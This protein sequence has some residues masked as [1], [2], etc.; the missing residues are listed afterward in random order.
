MRCNFDLAALA[1]GMTVE[2][3]LSVKVKGSLTHARFAA[4]ISRLVR[5]SSKYVAH[6][7][8]R[9]HTGDHPSQ[10]L[11]DQNDVDSFIKEV[12]EILERIKR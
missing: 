3:A 4:E 2:E 10:D 11:V 5:I 9:M 1:R 7:T 6:E 8:L 12:M